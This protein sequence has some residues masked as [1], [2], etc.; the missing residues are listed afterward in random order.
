MFRKVSC[1]IGVAALVMSCAS[2][3]ATKKYV[4]EGVGEVNDKVD[5]LGKSVEGTQE[6][7]RTSEGRISEVDQKA[8]NAAQAAQA[9]GGAA[10]QAN[11]AAAN[12][13]SA[14]NAVNG[15]VDAM[16]K[17]NRRLIFEVVLSDSEGN[18]KSNDAT[19]PDAAKQKIDEMIQRLKNDPK[20]VYIEIEGHTD[21]TG[22]KS[23]N[24]KLGLDRAQAVQRYLYEQYQIP[25]HK[26]N[27]ISYG[28]EKPVA[29]NNTKE[30]RAQNRRVVVRV[31]S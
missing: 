22:G 7:L 3:C 20:N 30:G 18:F 9:A 19:L 21:S 15:R 10:Q 13:A 14:A 17:N 26:M 5:S 31:L 23:I 27:V 1:A 2:A 12:A 8:Q 16:D 28:D 6:R 29:P 25:L 11:S 24:Q 4:K